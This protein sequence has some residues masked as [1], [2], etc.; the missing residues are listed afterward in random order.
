MSYTIRL[1]EEAELD[2]EEAAT[3][4]ESQSPGLGGQFL[5]T[6]LEIIDSFERAK[7]YVLPHRSSQYSSGC[8]TQISLLNFLPCAGLRNFCC[9]C[10]AR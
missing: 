6:V 3:W 8:S 9:I 1:R 7:P 10:Y 5:D 2:L 4:Y